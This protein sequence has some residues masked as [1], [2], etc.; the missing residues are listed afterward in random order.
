MLAGFQYC[1]PAT[2]HIVG[3]TQGF[4]RPVSVRLWFVFHFWLM[5]AYED[6]EIAVTIN[7]LILAASLLLRPRAPHSPSEGFDCEQTTGE[8]T[9]PESLILKCTKRNTNSKLQCTLVVYVTLIARMIYQKLD[10]S[11]KQ[12]F[13]LNHNTAVGEG[14][15]PNNIYIRIINSAYLRKT[16]IKSQD[17]FKRECR[18]AWIITRTNLS[19]GSVEGNSSTNGN[20]SRPYSATTYGLDVMCCDPR[21]LGKQ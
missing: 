15:Q 12:Y 14:E 21:N 1:P 6:D 11:C 19:V 3:S 13:P 10:T 16:H 7:L 18:K 5:M 8:R 9:P 2:S 17:I 4:A 20:R